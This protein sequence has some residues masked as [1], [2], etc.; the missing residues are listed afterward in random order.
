MRR[1]KKSYKNIM[2]YEAAYVYCLRHDLDYNNVD[3]FIL[4]LM[5]KDDFEGIMKDLR[6]HRRMADYQLAHIT[7]EEYELC[8]NEFGLDIFVNP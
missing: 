3:D 8:I 1:L 5:G 7:E 2:L 4:D 6:C